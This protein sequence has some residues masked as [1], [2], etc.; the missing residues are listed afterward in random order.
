M[1]LKVG[2]R[3]RA[4]T[5]EEGRIVALNDQGTLAHIHVNVGDKGVT[6]MRLLESLTRITIEAGAI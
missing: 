3:V 2:D 4:L 1:P 6:I 5:D